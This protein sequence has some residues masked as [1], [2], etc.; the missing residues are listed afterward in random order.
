M[1][2]M[3]LLIEERRGDQLEKNNLVDYLE[4]ILMLKVECLLLSVE[5]NLL[6]LK[7]VN[8]SLENLLLQNMVKIHI[9]IFEPQKPR[10]RGTP[11]K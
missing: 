5:L 1:E 4:V 8:I 3:E 7:V 9:Y 11:T 10:P 6:N 2:Q